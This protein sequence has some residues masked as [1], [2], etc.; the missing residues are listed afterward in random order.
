[1]SGGRTTAGTGLGV[2]GV[3]AAGRAHPG[4]GRPRW[5]PIGGR[6]QPRCGRTRRSAVAPAP[7]GPRGGSPVPCVGDSSHFPW[8]ST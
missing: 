6:T 1:M 4:G 2:R 8:T 7:T 3:C 5:M